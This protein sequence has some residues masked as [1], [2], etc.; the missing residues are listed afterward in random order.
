[1]Y[2]FFSVCTVSCFDFVQFAINIFKN[3]FSNGHDFLKCVNSSNT[4]LC[5]ILWSG[6]TLSSL[7]S[8]P[9]C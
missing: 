1:M 2:R 6:D 8:F 9:I 4:G 5:D 3:I 7:K